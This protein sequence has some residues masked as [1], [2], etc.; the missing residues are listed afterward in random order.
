MNLPAWWCYACLP[1]GQGSDETLPT[2]DTMPTKK[3]TG[4]VVTEPLQA[5]GKAMATVQIGKIQSE[6]P[7][8]KVEVAEIEV[9]G[10]ESY[11]YAEGV[12][13][14][15]RE[16][17]KGWA[18]I[19]DRI[20]EKTI[21]P[22]RSGL[23]E[24][25]QLNR[26]ADGPLA[27]LEDSIKG[28]LTGY[29]RKVLRQKAEEDAAKAREE[30][31]L[32]AEAEAKARAA[33]TAATPQMKGRLSAAAERLMQ[34]AATVAEQEPTIEAPTGSH[35]GVRTSKKLRIG[36]L[37]LFLASIVEGTIPRDVLPMEE[38]VSTLTKKW[39]SDPDVATWPGVEIYDDV[40]VVNK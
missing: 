6:L 20:Q 25:Y 23:E 19:W 21:K 31:R 10:P 15:V 36:D 14:R 1:A 5:N 13:G 24:L 30:A 29:Q 34:Q 37:D 3:A 11:A 16:I 38:L 17:R 26:D 32:Q 2:G 9:T 22:I 40:Q 27:I 39:K 18:T 35:S 28:K 8:L 7:S 33:Q 4:A 12:L